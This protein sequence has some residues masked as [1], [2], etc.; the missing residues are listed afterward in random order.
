MQRHSS[1]TNFEYAARQMQQRYRGM[2]ST[3]SV[4]G[5]SPSDEKGKRNGHL[6]ALG[7]EEENLYPGI[8]GAGGA[9]DFFRQRGL[10][11]WKSSRSGDDD[12]NKYPTRNMAS[13]QVA[14]V[15]FMLPLAGIDGALLSLSRAI[16]DDVC[17]IADIH[18]EGNASQVEFEWIGLGRSLEGGSTRGSQNTSIDAFLVAE[19]E[20][21]RRRA[22]LLEWKYVEQY[23]RTQPDFK[24]EGRAGDTRRAQEPGYT[25]RH[26][27]AV[28]PSRPR[29][30]KP[31]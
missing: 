16:D 19:T 3:V 1:R 4:R 9:I 24:G 18:H 23:Q 29:S 15:N 17:R 20:T 31:A 30:P 28:Q 10:G 5:R 21:G 12:D 8:R 7:C 2:S 13:S 26:G 14:C 11:W 25:I 6:L 27:G 22:Y